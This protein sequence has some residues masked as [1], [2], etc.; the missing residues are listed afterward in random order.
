MS[1]PNKKIIFPGNSNRQYLLI[2]RSRTPS[3]KPE[4]FTQLKPDESKECE[5]SH[6]L[7]SSGF[8]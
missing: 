7:L 6:S 8:N 4:H 1:L 5:F 2:K 3:I